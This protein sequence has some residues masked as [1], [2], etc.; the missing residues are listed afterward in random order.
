MVIR[1]P[2]KQTQG[3]VFRGKKS[4]W[5]IMQINDAALRVSSDLVTKKLGNKMRSWILECRG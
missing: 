5:E 1:P 4:K 3:I 2:E